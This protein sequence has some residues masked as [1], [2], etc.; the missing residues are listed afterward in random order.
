MV[1]AYNGSA[2]FYTHSSGLVLI[3]STTIGS[4]VSSV[5][6][7]GAFSSTYENYRIIVSGGVASGSV[8]VKLQLGSTTTGYYAFRIYG[9]YNAAT[10][11]GEQTNNGANFY[12]GF[13]STN[14]I[15]GIMDV[16]GPNAAKR[17][18]VFGYGAVP[19]LSSLGPQIVGGFED[20]A[21]QHTAFTILPDSNQTFTG[22]TIR[23]YG[24]KN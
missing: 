8:N 3:S 10:V 22:G 5:T 7:S 1:A 13:A 24:Y 4:A 2:W 15:F 14:T 23:V 6:V 18:T 9:Q 20:S 12:M 21:T 17:T 16:S 11:T 19:A